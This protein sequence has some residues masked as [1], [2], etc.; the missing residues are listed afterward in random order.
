MSN[1][2]DINNKAI[3]TVLDFNL[4]VMMELRPGSSTQSWTQFT[5]FA[6]DSVTDAGKVN[7]YIAGFQKKGISNKYEYFGHF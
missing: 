1:Y 3:F 4:K 5:A 6:L 2:D 7:V